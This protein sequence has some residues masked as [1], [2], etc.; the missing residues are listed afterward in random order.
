MNK[1]VLCVL[2][3]VYLFIPTICTAQQYTR[4]EL[5]ALLKMIEAA[6]PD[7]TKIYL[8]LQ[9]AYIYIGRAG[10]AQSDM[11]SALILINHAALLNEKKPVQTQ[12]L[13][14]R[15]LKGQILLEQ[16]K[17]A[18]AKKVLL[19]VARDYQDIGEEEKS[20]LPIE[21]YARYLPHS[22]SEK[23]I[24]LRQ[25]ELA[26]RAL[27]KVKKALGIRLHVVGHQ[28]SSGLLDSALVNVELLLKEW[29]DV[30]GPEVAQ[31]YS[32]RAAIHT[33]YGNYEA[34]LEDQL[35]G[36][37][38]I[39]SKEW[40]DSDVEYAKS[41]LHFAYTDIGRAY[42]QLKNYKKATEW[43]LLG[44]EQAKIRYQNYIY[45]NCLAYLVKSMIYEG[46]AREALNLVQSVSRQFLPMSEYEKQGLAFAFA[47]CYD[48]LHQ[49]AL[50]KEN[51]IVA[52]GF[53]KVAN[54]GDH[55]EEYLNA[56]ADFYLSRGNYKDA[57][58]AALK[59]ISIDD[60][61]TTSV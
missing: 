40:A 22:S 13:Y 18:E 29:K 34:V 14:G 50:A 54:W 3:F 27:G 19:S 42:Y 49:D 44:L 12:I 51:Y 30:K 32:L 59:V 8:Q 26:Y 41:L 58:T 10:T 7:T 48:A 20:I 21:L 23:K 61:T 2:I 28:Y 33:Y 31:V 36:L 60:S 35:Q 15:V 4:K 25:A 57:K 6:P 9:A 46:Q 39:D 1:L 52:I 24:Y 37:K 5:P 17:F 47:N 43:Y 45:A 38:I 16:D 53:G 55:N 11:D 56:E